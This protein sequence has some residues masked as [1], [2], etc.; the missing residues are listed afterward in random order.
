MKTKKDAFAKYGIVQDNERWSWSGINTDKIPT[1]DPNIEL[2]LCVMTIWT[3][4][5]KFNNAKFRFLGL[6]HSIIGNKSFYR[7][8]D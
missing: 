4:Q 5:R 2:P 1:I 6:Y 3:D 8:E 7:I